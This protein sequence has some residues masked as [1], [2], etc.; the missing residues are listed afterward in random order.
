MALMLTID[1]DRE[2]LVDVSACRSAQPVVLIH[3]IAGN[4]DVSVPLLN[5]NG[6]R[7]IPVNKL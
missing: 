3:G 5:K 4:F 1:I 7:T 6:F 2:H